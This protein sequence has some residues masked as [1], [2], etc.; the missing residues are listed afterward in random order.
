MECMIFLAEGCNFKC[1]YCYEGHNKA[2][3]VMNSDT[4]QQVLKFM[5]ENSEEDEKMHIVFLGGEP[6]LNKKV[7]LYAIEKINT[8]YRKKRKQFVFEMTTNGVFLDDKIIEIVR[9]E[10]I[11]LSLSI[12][13]TKRTHDLNRKS[14]G[15]E[16]YYELIVN[17]IKTMVK[18]KI[19]FNVRMTV[20]SNNVF[21][22]YNNVCYFLNLG[23]NRVYISYDYF[24]NWTEDCL[25]ELEVQMSLLDRLYIDEFAYTE[26]RILNLYDFKYTTFLSKRPAVFCSAGTIG[27]YIVNT[28]GEIYPC[29]YV[30]NAEEW[31]IG[32]VWTGI[33]EGIFKRNI[34]KHVNKI[35]ECQKCEMKFSCLATRCGFLNYKTTGTLNAPKDTTCKLEKILYKHNLFV[36]SE[37][38]KAHCPRLLQ[39]VGVAKTYKLE[40]ND[41]VKYMFE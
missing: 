8:D 19:P 40:P 17:W 5:V 35:Q 24:A 39:Y 4:M 34:R 41:C 33:K 13:G 26:N 9:K 1:T 16:D 36:L 21:D 29:S 31:K 2:S 32:D 30:A 23:V 14:K 38:Y 6:L 11:N 20:S 22:M 25:A 12:D 3:G 15:G 18:D 27:H 37:L 7:F 10:Q 28:C